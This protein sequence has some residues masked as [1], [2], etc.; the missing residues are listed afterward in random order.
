MRPELLID[1]LLDQIDR[2]RLLLRRLACYLM[3]VLLLPIGFAVAQVGRGWVAALIGMFGGAVLLVQAALTV[4]PI[5]VR[6]R[7][8]N[9][10]V[11]RYL[12][13]GPTAEP[14]S[15]APAA[16]L[17]LPA[18]LVMLVSMIAFGAP[19]LSQA[20]LWQ[21]GLALALGLFAIVTIWQHL[22]MIVASLGTLESRLRQAR[23]RIPAPPQPAPGR[24][25]PPLLDAA[26]ARRVA[27]MP[28]SPLPLSP[29]A[30]ALLRIEAYLALQEEPARGEHDLLATIGA[31][32][33]ACYADERC[34]AL[35]PPVGGKIYL[36]VAA[37]GTIAQMLG[38]TAQALGMDGAYSASL[39]TWLVRL[40][41]ARS[42][43]VAGRLIDAIIALRL[44]PAGRVYPHHLTVQGD[45][46]QESRALSLLYLACAP[47]TL[48]ERP[49]RAGGD[50]R[51][52][53]MRGGGVLDDLS[54]RGRTRGPRTD[55]VDGFLVVD[56]PQFR[57]P[58]QLAAHTQNLRLKQ[59]LGFGLLAFLAGRRTP[60]EEAAAGRYALFRR[61]LREFLARYGLAG[62]LAVDWIDGRWSD[63]WPLIERTNRLKQE[64]PDFLEEAAA[65][66]DRTLDD[67]ER[68]ATA[69]VL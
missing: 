34:H 69:G 23:E 36:P 11:S 47:V 18:A 58:E 14:P 17:A 54:G 6:A 30:V 3:P 7:I 25:M 9:R 13:L 44:L 26:I 62:A 8:N 41:P 39:G 12:G 56:A 4:Q 51:P 2:D 1:R 67:L 52:F 15:L 66:R 46:G 68:I 21:R 61:E 40:P 33:H 22:A 45:M 16:A 59:V 29:G 42:Y 27:G 38:A 5:L 19:I 63:V 31:L 24:G 43:R 64:S 20:P 32:A 49:G 48:E 60:P 65:L 50:E 10:D 37:S 57:D 35:L 28:L 53:I 55:F